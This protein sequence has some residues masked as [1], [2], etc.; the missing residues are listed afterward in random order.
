MTLVHHQALRHELV[1]IIKVRKNI[2]PSRLL[3]QNF[4]QIGFD[5]VDLVDII[6]EVE[7]AYQIFIP[8]EVPLHKVDDFVQFIASQSLEIQA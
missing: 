1:Q 7:K 6:L 3:S 8:D 2:E 5:S 4:E